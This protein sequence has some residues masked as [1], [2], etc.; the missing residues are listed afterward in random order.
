[1]YDQGVQRPT[2]SGGKVRSAAVKLLTS[3]QN[4]VPLSLSIIS[5]TRF[6][7]T[8]YLHACRIDQLDPVTE[9]YRR[10]LRTR[11]FHRVR[12]RQQPGCWSPRRLAQRRPHPRAADEEA[13][14]AAQALLAASASW[15]RP[16]LLVPPMQPCV[17]TNVDRY[18]RVAHRA[19]QLA[20]GD[21]PLACALHCYELGVHLRQRVDRSSWSSSHRTQG[22]HM[23]GSGALRRA[24][25][26]PLLHSRVLLATLPR[27]RS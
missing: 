23:A 8:F 11:A 10:G 5:S 27:K 24:W 25:R 18:C 7:C 1:M 22:G 2:L 4:V 13:E 19:V 3:V 17:L 9:L 15:W 6:G 21:A 26:R 16:S 14:A 12:W 20:H